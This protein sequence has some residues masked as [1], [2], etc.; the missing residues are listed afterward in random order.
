M[1]VLLFSSHPGFATSDCWGNRTLRPAQ[2]LLPPGLVSRFLGI[3]KGDFGKPVTT[4][5]LRRTTRPRTTSAFVQLTPS[6]REGTALCTDRFVFV[7]KRGKLI[8]AVR[9]YLAALN[10]GMWYS[11]DWKTMNDPGRW[12]GTRKVFVWSGAGQSWYQDLANHSRHPFLGIIISKA[13]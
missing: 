1:Y 4:W 7:P 2:P 11:V 3:K 10:K 8:T 9:L 13:Q 12:R 6:S 5:G